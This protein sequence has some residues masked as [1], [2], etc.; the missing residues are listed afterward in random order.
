MAS[1]IKDH[2]ACLESLPIELI[3]RIAGYLPCSSAFA[4]MSANKLLYAACNDRLLFKEIA[5][6][7]KLPQ[8]F[9]R[10]GL[11]NVTLEWLDAPVLLDKASLSDTIRVAYA[12]DRATEQAET[13]CPQWFDGKEMH[14]DV[15]NWLPQLIALRH[16]TCLV[17]GPEHLLRL[18]SHLMM[19]VEE[20]DPCPIASIQIL[21][22]EFC[23]ISLILEH[24]S[25]GSD[26]YHNCKEQWEVNMRL[27]PGEVK[28]YYM[29]IQSGIAFRLFR[30]MLEFGEDM[31][32]FDYAQASALILHLPFFIDEMHTMVGLPIPFPEVARMPFHKWMDIPM[33]YLKD[34]K[35][36]WQ[37]HIAKMA[38]PSFISGVWQGYYT[39]D[40]DGEHNLEDPMHDVNL[41]TSEPHSHPESNTKTVIDGSSRGRDRVGRFTIHGAVY[42]DGEVLM[43]K[44]YSGGWEWSYKGFVTPFGIAGIWGDEEWDFGGYFW[45]WKKEWCDPAARYTVS[46]HGF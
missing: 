42:N 31:E 13:T 12:V 23:M 18:H 44:Q 29:E 14:T 10:T 36:L 45:L 34:S 8:S 19:E 17:M 3:R 24:I 11:K 6:H 26:F 21:N 27:Y 41:S 40:R 16:P 4:L 37:G 5:E 43:T 35:V 22:V 9:F 2:S 46:G 7:T 28:E 30:R 32:D 25:R 1:L 20:P 38:T 33:V 39:D 15:R